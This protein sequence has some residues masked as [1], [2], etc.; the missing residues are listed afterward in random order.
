ITDGQIFLESNLFNAGVRPAINVGIS[1]SRVGGSAQ[2]KS[3]KKVAGTLKLDQA[4]YRELEAFAKFGSDLDI[5]I[6]DHIDFGDS[7]LFLDGINNRV[8]IGTRTPGTALSIGGHVNGTGNLSGVS[9]KSILGK[10]YHCSVGQ[11]DTHNVFLKWQYN[12]IASDGFASL[13]TFGGS[14]SLVLQEGGGNIGIGYTNPRALLGIRGDVNGTGNLPGV[15]MKSVDGTDYHY[16]VGQD[17]THNAFLKWKYNATVN[18]GYAELATWGGTNPLVLQGTAGNVGVGLTNPASPFHVR[19]PG[20]TPTGPSGI[21]ASRVENLV[22]AATE[23]GLTVATRYGNSGSKIFEAASYWSGSNEEYTPIL[24][25]LGNRKI[26][27]NGNTPFA[28]LHLINSGAPAESGNINSGLGISDGYG[29]R[30]INLGVDG[31]GGYGWIQSTFANN[32]GITQSLSINPRGGNVGIGLTAPNYTLD[33]EGNTRSGKLFLGPT[34]PVPISGG[35]T[36]FIDI[37]SGNTEHT[38]IEISNEVVSGGIELESRSATSFG[39]GIMN[40]GLQT[41]RA[42]MEKHPVV[43]P[44]GLWM[45][46]DNRPA[47]KAVKWIFE[48][49]GQDT[50]HI[51]MRLMNDGRLRINETYALPNFDGSNGQALITDGSGNLSW[52]APSSGIWSTSGGNIYRDGFGQVGIGLSNPAS[53]LH[54]RRLG[55]NPTGPS[56]IWAARVDNLVDNPTENG[57]TV[58][59][60][61]ASNGSKIF[62]VATYWNGSSETYTPFLTATGAQ[63]VGIGTVNPNNK[64][65]VDGGST[66][67]TAIEISNDLVSG[68]IELESRSVTSFGQGIMNV[69]LQTNR[70]I[71][72]KHPVVLPMGLWMQMDTRP[73]ERAVKWIFEDFGQDTEHVRMRLM[74]DGRLRLNE[75]YSLPN[76]DGSSGQL[77]FTDGSGNVSWGSG[78]WSTVG[79]NIYRNLGNVGIGITTPGV[80]LHVRENVPSGHVALFEN[81]NNGSAHG[82]EVRLHKTDTDANNNFMTFRDGANRITGRIEGFQDNGTLPSAPVFQGGGAGETVFRSC[83]WP[84]PNDI[85]NTSDFNQWQS[86]LINRW[87]PTPF[88]GG[89]DCVMEPL[90]ISKG[91]MSKGL[92]NL[93]AGSINLPLGIGTVNLPSIP[94]PEF[95]PLDVNLP[96]QVPF[97]YND[98]ANGNLPWTAQ[99]IYNTVCWAT[100]NGYEDFLSVSNPI[101]FATAALI[102]KAK[103]LCNDGGVTYGSKGAD[104]AEWLLKED[105]LSQFALGEVVGIRNGK[106]TKETQNVDQIMV[107]SSRP[108]VLGN[109]PEEGKE[110]NYEKVGFMGQVLTL[111]QGGAKAGDYTLFQVVIIMVGGKLFLLKR[112]RSKIFQISSER[113][114]LI[115]KMTL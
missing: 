50:E 90:S 19:R 85:N 27:I 112:S 43:S 113:L 92:S 89:T 33:I 2:I 69:G 108:V 12:A 28:P 58:A 41:N 63:R 84:I 16:S 25:V 99:Q 107:V 62:E 94:L 76:H 52:G 21:W 100:D 65:H 40:I 55:A 61:H 20:T 32:A 87:L 81:I 53:P 8:G 9:M 104:Y 48:D 86:W 10:N 4:S 79:G 35:Y 11:D 59:T 60:R 31:A 83:M 66:E 47:E 5:A 114:G 1:V 39:Q 24:S 75:A 64:L 74:H 98:I 51:R 97:Y 93:S 54:V 71:M 38:A 110:Q 80:K 88:G 45:Q 56:G 17:D 115:Q 101:E 3:M 68:G 18:E 34:D 14:N 72:E 13:S 111:V 95:P 44:M 67:H 78:S 102:I 49:Y 26:G 96:Y 23:N 15:S 106:I 37:E 30:S 70:T 46:I 29:G 109:T 103:S 6:P 42:I 77:L 22:D 73:T 7:T 82:I 57:L 91:A 105:T 36:N